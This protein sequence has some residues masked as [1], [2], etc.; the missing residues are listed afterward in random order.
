MRCKKN[1]SLKIWFYLQKE[2]QTKHVSKVKI[3]LNN[4]PQLWL[5]REKWT[6]AC[7]GSF[8]SGTTV[9]GIVAYLVRW[10][11]KRVILGG[12]EM[13]QKNSTHCEST[14]WIF[15]F[16]LIIKIIH[17]SINFQKII[18]S[19]AEKH[20]PLHL[21]REAFNGYALTRRSRSWAQACAVA[22]E[23]PVG[24]AA[25]WRSSNVTPGIPN[26]TISPPPCWP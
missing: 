5:L 15:I 26:N 6:W 21:N 4:F 11:S 20:R 19:I 3:H 18:A 25:A 10:I 2:V 1:T 9:V 22:D 13:L 17:R 24:V 7:I 8:S 16:E 23:S 14:W 12:N